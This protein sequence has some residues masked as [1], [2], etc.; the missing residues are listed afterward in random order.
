M[1]E[2]IIDED[3]ADSQKVDLNIWMCK[4]DNEKELLEE[5][6]FLENINGENFDFSQK[7]DRKKFCNLLYKNIFEDEN[8]QFWG[9]DL[10]NCFE[11]LEK[12]FVKYDYA[13]QNY[14]IHLYIIQMGKQENILANYINCFNEIYEAAYQQKDLSC[15]YLQFAYL[16]CAR[17]INRICTVYN[18]ER[19]FDDKKLMNKAHSLS[20]T[21]ER[22]SMGD[23]LA[24]LIG[25]NTLSDWKSGELYAKKVLEGREKNEKHIAFVY[26]CLGHFYEYN[27]KNEK[28]SWKQYKKML[29]ICP[30]NYRATFKKACHNLDDKEKA[31]QDFIE[32][33]KQMKEKEESRDIQPL[34]IEY[35]YKC[36]C[37][38]NNAFF[39]EI[40]EKYDFKIQLHTVNEIKDKIFYN[41]D[42]NIKLFGEELETYQEYFMDKMENH[43]F[44]LINRS[45]NGK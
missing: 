33:Y 13:Y 26:Y 15:Q 28:E 6:I 22:F 34:E 12:I 16:N 40:V 23:T 45:K 44:V 4:E 14:V 24:A 36:I 11:I 32:I 3:D 8:Q 7:T 17:K 37:I 38:L 39:S 5:N 20:E 30:N 31:C 29:E 42:F 41:S 18:I 9:T 21:D 25:L 43:N 35:Y 27:R 2:T 10:L 1:R 19:I